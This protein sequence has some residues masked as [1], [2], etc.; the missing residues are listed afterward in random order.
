[1]VTS[2]DPGLR[3]DPDKRRQQDIDANES[4]ARAE[5]ITTSPN[6]LAEVMHSIRHAAKNQ[7]NVLD[8][9]DEVVFRGTL[10]QCEDWLDLQENRRIRYESGHNW[11]T[12]FVRRILGRSGQKR[13]GSN[14]S[15]PSGSETES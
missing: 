1:M 11:L 14:H 13:V 5:P 2:F 4:E 9:N 6:Q 3:A 7:W 10:S 12:R 15:K 8:E